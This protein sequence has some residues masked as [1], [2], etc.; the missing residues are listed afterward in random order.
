MAVFANRLLST[1]T[2]QLCKRKTGDKEKQ[3][4]PACLQAICPLMEAEAEEL[5]KVGPEPTSRVMGD[6]RKDR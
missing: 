2:E 5:S 1:F 3:E 4:N 6:H